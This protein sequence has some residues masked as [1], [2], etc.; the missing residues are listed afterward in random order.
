HSAQENRRECL[1]LLLAHGADLSGRNATHHNTP[2]YFL[3]GHRPGDSQA[4]T[5][6]EGMEWLLEHGADPNVTSYDS[7]ETPLH[8]AARTGWRE[9]AALFLAHGADVNARR[10]DRRTP[11]VIAVRNGHDEL[12]ALL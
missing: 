7:A 8:A 2:L 5:A 1:E 3:A 9:A 10:A 4:R 6:L 11:Y 12:V